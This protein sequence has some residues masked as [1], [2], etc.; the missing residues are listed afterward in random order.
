MAQSS[1]WVVLEEAGDTTTY[2]M[3]LPRGTI[4]RTHTIYRDT[5]KGSFAVAAP[6]TAAT[7]T[8]VFLEGLTN[9]EMIKGQR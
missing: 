3:V 4:I 9:L 2:A 5:S 1:L 7:E 6:I 8:T